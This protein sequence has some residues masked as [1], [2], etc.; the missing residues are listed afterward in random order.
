MDANLGRHLRPPLAQIAE[1][2]LERLEEPAHR[3]AR[4]A[5]ISL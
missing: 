3:Q 5:H 2:G 1:G 4:R